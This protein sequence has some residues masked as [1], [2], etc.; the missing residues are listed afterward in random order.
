VF[1]GGA[2]SVGQEHV[3][4]AHGQAR[5]GSGRRGPLCSASAAP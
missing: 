3:K 5:G 1:A 2:P 4:I